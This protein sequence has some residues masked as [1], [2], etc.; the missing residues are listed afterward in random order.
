MMAARVIQ[1][2][3]PGMASPPPSPAA[4][5]MRAELMARIAK[6]RPYSRRR[7]ELEARLRDMT[8]RQMRLEIELRAAR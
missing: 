2:F 4:A 5:E 1:P 7:L 8:A 3:P 6:L